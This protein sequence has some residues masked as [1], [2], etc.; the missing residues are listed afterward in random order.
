MPV[1][2]I[3]GGVF[4]LRADFTEQASNGQSAK[5]RGALKSEYLPIRKAFA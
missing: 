5:I 4:G 3:C 2:G 1:C